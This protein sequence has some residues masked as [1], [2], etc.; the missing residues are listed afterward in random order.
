VSSFSLLEAVRDAH[1]RAVR[2]VEAIRD[3]ELELAVMLADD[4]AH[5]LWGIVERKERAS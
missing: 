4:L 1:A 5:D 2:I 3:G